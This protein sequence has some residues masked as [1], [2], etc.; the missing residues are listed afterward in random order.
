MEYL[1]DGITFA[2]KLGIEVKE[3]EIIRANSSGLAI[4]DP[5]ILADMILDM[6]K[7]TNQTREEKIKARL[8][9]ES[10]QKQAI[11]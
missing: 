4:Y 10:E 7:N 9:Y 8:L 6:D 1:D 3:E 11:N 5:N 2:N